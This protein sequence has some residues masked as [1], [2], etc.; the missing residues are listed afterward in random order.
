MADYLP[1]PDIEGEWLMDWGGAQR[2]LKTSAPAVEIFNACRTVGGHATRYYGGNTDEPVFQPL[3]GPLLQ[4]HSNV[5]DAFDPDRLI[6]AG[7]YHPEI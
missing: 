6:N 3:E 2:W 5:R 1:L 4:L 7:R